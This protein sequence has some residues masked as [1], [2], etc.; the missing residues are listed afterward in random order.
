MVDYQ[1]LSIVL[2]GIGIIVAIIYYAQVLRNTEK[3]RQRDLIFLRFQSFDLEWTRAWTNVLFNGGDSLEEW[4]QY[5]NP[6]EKPENFADMLLLQTRYQSIGLMLKE[7]VVDPDLLF[8]IYQPRSIITTWEHYERNIRHRREI[9]NN[10]ELLDCFE[11]LSLQAKKRVGDINT[12]M[13]KRQ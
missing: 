13:P 8:K 10:S 7:K 1:T 5:F 4:E 12:D 6:T 3:A 9:T 2:T 11:Y